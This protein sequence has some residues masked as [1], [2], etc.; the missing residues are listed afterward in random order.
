MISTDINANT[1]VGKMSESTMNQLQRLQDKVRALEQQNAVLRQNHIESPDDQHLLNGDD[2]DNRSEDNSVGSSRRGSDGI[3]SAVQTGGGVDSDSG[4]SSRQKRSSATGLDDVS[5]IDIHSLEGGESD[6]LIQ[7]PKQG[8]T[9]SSDEDILEWLRTDSDADVVKGSKSLVRRLDDLAKRSP[10]HGMYSPNSS[11]SSRG[12]VVGSPYLSYMASTPARKPSRGFES[13][14]EFDPRTFTRGSRGLSSYNYTAEDGGVRRTSRDNGYHRLAYGASQQTRTAAD[15]EPAVSGGMLSCTY[16]DI[17]STSPIIAGHHQQQHPSQAAGMHN[18]PLNSNL[19]CTLPREGLSST[20][21]KIADEAEQNDRP[22]PHVAANSTF[23]RGSPVK[24]SSPPSAASASNNRTFD[25]VNTP[26]KPANQTFDSAEKPANTTYNSTE[27]AN[28]RTF[29][30]GTKTNNRTFVNSTS[31]NNRTFD[32]ENRTLMMESG[33]PAAVVPSNKA[34]DSANRTFEKDDNQRK[35]SEDRLSSASSSNRLSRGSSQDGLLED[36][37]VLSADIDRLSTTSGLSE[38]SVSHRLNDVQDVQDV[39]RMQE[40]SLRHPQSYN[41]PRSATMSPSS[42]ASLCSPQGEEAGGYQSEESCGSES[43]GHRVEPRRGEGRANPAYRHQQQH[44]GMKAYGGSSNHHHPQHQQQ[45]YGGNQ[46][47]SQDSLPDSPYS[48][49]SL[50]SHNSQQGPDLRRSMPNLNKLRGRGG[51][52]G[53]GSG[54]MPRPQYGL[55]QARHHNSD[56]RLQPGSRLQGPGRVSGSSMRMMPAGV[57]VHTNNSAHL[58]SRASA[59]TSAGGHHSMEQARFAKPEPVRKASS[60]ISRPMGGIPRPG[61]S[62]LP[63]PRSGIA[64]GASSTNRRTGSVGPTSR[65]AAPSSAHSRHAQPPAA[66]NQN[67]QED[68]Y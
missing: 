44:Y 68:C 45:Q 23:R 13:R 25:S 37:E 58:N 53:R 56:G 35:M 8:N 12:S 10:V 42:E 21:D 43:G 54:G 30:S 40:E 63:A 20:F 9:I 2:D 60:G 28:N 22:S 11:G 6:W 61:G 46:Y 52:S 59:P 16:D 57:Q 41:Q 49:Q 3:S 32:A 51:A 55:S 31:S 66:H 39:A 24:R 19:N 29:D 48:S 62:R 5:L 64:R 38:S 7:S 27:S 15:T 1:G 50:D 4:S 36:M 67:W 18:G 14:S 26:V 47:S 17:D 34:C 65:I 33:K